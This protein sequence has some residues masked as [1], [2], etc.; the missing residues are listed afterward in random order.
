M[1]SV[2]A[3]CQI[4]LNDGSV[5]SMSGTVVEGTETELQTSTTYSVSATS[6][7]Q[8]ADGKTITSF[9]Q[10]VSCLNGVA[11]AYIN[12]RGSIAAIV[13]IAKQGITQ[14]EPMS[15]CGQAGFALQ[16]G[17]TLQVM[18]NTAADREFAWMVRT[19]QGVSAIFSATPSGS[20]N[21]DL[22]HILSGQG[23]GTSL[24]GQTVIQ[25]ASSSVDGSKL[26]T[27]GVLLLNDKGLPVNGCTATNPQDQR[28]EWSAPST[29]TPI[30]LNFVARVTTS[31]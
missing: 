9:I 4:Q 1:A 2:N 25:Q 29:M 6:L 14:T 27:G 13:P 16:A 12:R 15:F 24:V 28:L 31:S 19:N 17:D 22:T 23:A 5:V 7:G 21:S 3:Q 20:G 8:F 18:A 30:G 10:P 26:S 11:Y